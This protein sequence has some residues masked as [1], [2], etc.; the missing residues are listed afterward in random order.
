MLTNP[1]SGLATTE[2]A[3]GMI[4][5]TNNDA[6][7][8]MVVTLQPGNALLS[9]T[10]E[11]D[12]TLRG[13]SFNGFWGCFSASACNTLASQVDLDVPHGLVHFND[14]GFL[15]SLIAPS[16]T[17]VI[18]RGTVR[19]LPRFVSGDLAIADA[20]AVVDGTT[21]L[22]L[23]DGGWGPVNDVIS[24]GFAGH[25]TPTRRETVAVRFDAV[26]GAVRGGSYIYSDSSTNA[27]LGYYCGADFSLP[28][29]QGVTLNMAAGTLVL[30][31]MT[32]NGVQSMNIT[33]TPTLRVSGSFLFD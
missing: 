23:V 12:G 10:F 27:V 6:S 1:P 29:C 24:L 21:P 26:T 16:Q 18:T 17:T 11:P 19:Y 30:D 31:N 5:A 22:T 2:Q 33:G 20:P 4:V 25:R 3:N 28:D 8:S 7:V 32:L 15:P 14:A 13:G 9:L